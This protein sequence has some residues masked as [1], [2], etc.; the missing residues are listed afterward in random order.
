MTGNV[1]AGLQ[2]CNPATKTQA[3]SSTGTAC[4][5]SAF[6]SGSLVAKYVEKCN[7]DFYTMTR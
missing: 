7:P 5:T 1:T 3:K 4:T 6:K 2:N